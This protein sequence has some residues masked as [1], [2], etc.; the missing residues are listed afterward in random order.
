M[1][2]VPEG[3][4]ALVTGAA[5]GIGRATPSCSRAPARTWWRP[6]PTPSAGEALAVEGG[7]LSR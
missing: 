2:D 7:L 3:E 1:D 5:S 4:V 6:T